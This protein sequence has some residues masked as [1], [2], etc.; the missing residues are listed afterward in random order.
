MQ[1]MALFIITTRM[2]EKNHGLNYNLNT[3]IPC[4]QPDISNPTLLFPWTFSPT[5]FPSLYRRSP[6][7]SLLFVGDFH[8]T[9]LI[10]LHPQFQFFSFR[11]FCPVC[12]FPIFTPVSPC[13]LF[14]SIYH[15][16]PFCLP[17]HPIYPIS[18]SYSHSH[19]HVLFYT[20]MSHDSFLC[21]FLDSNLDYPYLSINTTC[22]AARCHRRLFLTIPPASPP[23]PGTFSLSTT[24]TDL[25]S[26]LFIH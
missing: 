21:P 4:S 5:S 6:P 15:Y 12:L 1:I 22:L 16:L 3:G 7:L 20:S 14:D 18:H 13:H 19:M 9:I 25:P 10:L 23:T 17:I 8:L 26:V 24:V 11:H 2:N